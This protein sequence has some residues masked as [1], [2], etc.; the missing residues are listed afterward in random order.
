MAKLVSKTYADALFELAVEKGCED[1][2]LEDAK[3]LLEILHENED[4]AKMMNHPQIVKEEKLQIIENIFKGKTADEIV[5]LMCQLIE[6]AHFKDMESVF[7]CFVDSVKESK[8]IGTAY[9]ISAME[10]S[11]QQKDEIVKKLLETTHYVEI[12]MNYEVDASLIGGMVIRIKDR[13]VDSSI[14][15]R[16]QKLTS[17]LSKIQLKVGETAS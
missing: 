17:E 2:W 10:L 9:V 16:L 4:L 14:K 1:A 6:K 3:A 15:T 12:E 8:N 7:A 13:V 5:G 11:M